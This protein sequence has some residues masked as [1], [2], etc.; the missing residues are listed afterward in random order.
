VSTLAAR[1]AHKRVV[2]CAGAG[3]VGKTTVAATI[4]LG[5]AAQGR[6]VAVV[7]IDP[8]RRLAEALG[9][10]QLGNQPRLVDPERFRR[11]GFEVNGEL[12]AMMLDTKRTFDELIARLAPD[13]Y[14]RDQ[15]LDNRIYR[16][17]STAVAG[18]Q[19]YT[20][21]AKLFELEHQGDYE[22][23]VLDTPPSRSAMDFLDAPERLIGFLG[24][25]ALS[26]FLAPTRRALRAAGIV[27]AALRRIT[28][29]GLLEDLTTF[30]RLTSGLL[31]GFRTRA[32]D[33]QALLTD[34][35]TAF[36]IVTSPEG[37]ALDEAIRFAAQLERAGMHRCGVIV[38]RVHALDPDEHTAATTEARLAPALGARLG[39]QVA[40]AHADVQILARRDRAALQRLRTALHE[41][42]PMCLADRE[43]DVHDIHGIAD[44]HN[45]LFSRPPSA[46]NRR[47]HRP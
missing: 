33:V 9:L 25:R 2:I 15:I 8:A 16:H 43:T 47:S 28:G 27:F 46:V 38:N 40:R 19:E 22:T 39:R 21:I 24:A 30:F 37:A 13:A 5:L 18:S 7:T 17:L 1:L 12:H 23:I 45:E 36:V 35:T 14:T 3:G 31:G 29:V 32:T 11:S 6:R 44:L 42:E 10:D 4:A 41:P 34:H 26:P 20:A